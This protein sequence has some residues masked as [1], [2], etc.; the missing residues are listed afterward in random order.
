MPWSHCRI[1]GMIPVG[2]LWN[3]DFFGISYLDGY[4]GAW[5]FPSGVRQVVLVCAAGGEVCALWFMQISSTNRSHR[6]LWIHLLHVKPMRPMRLLPK[7][8]FGRTPHGNQTHTSVYQSHTDRTP[9]SVLHMGARRCAPDRTSLAHQCASGLT[10][11]AIVHKLQ[12]ARE[13]LDST[14][15]SREKGTDEN[16]KLSSL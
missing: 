8:R 1:F 14:K 10:P 9:V 15:I 6:A 3:L 5:W 12:L 7:G 16:T 13:F 11:V 2:N 4:Q